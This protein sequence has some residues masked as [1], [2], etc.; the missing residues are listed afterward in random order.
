[1]AHAAGVWLCQPPSLQDKGATMLCPTLMDA[2]TSTLAPS[3][4]SVSHSTCWG[5][6][7]PLTSALAPRATD[8]R[9]S[10]RKS[11]HRPGFAPPTAVRHLS[12]CAAAHLSGSGAETGPSVAAASPQPGANNRWRTQAP[13]A[14][15]QHAW[16]ASSQSCVPLFMHEH[17]LPA[18]S[19]SPG[20]LSQQGSPC[21]P[22]Q[23]RRALAKHSQM[24]PGAIG[25]GTVSMAAE[26]HTHTQCRT[27][28][29]LPLRSL[30]QLQRPA[31]VCVRHQQMA[32]RE[33][34]RASWRALQH[35]KMRQRARE[36]AR[37]ALRHQR[38]AG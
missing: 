17:N 26:R 30:A 18:M 12:A 34:W 21:S 8:S 13:H 31:G 22:S 37:G 24:A 4:V 38:T 23:Y 20:R 14:S 35:Q 6:C 36:S 15:R 16:Q 11:T 19:H 27:P 9:A 33:S 29:A 7:W 3:A 25:Q 32:E 2:H 1:M 10:L 28:D 5:L